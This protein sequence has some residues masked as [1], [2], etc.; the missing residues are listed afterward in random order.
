M[1]RQ[2]AGLWGLELIGSKGA[3]KILTEAIPK[4]YLLKSSDWTAQGR[5]N[6]WHPWPE[7]PT[8]N[9]STAEKSFGPSNRRGVDDWLDSIKTR[10]D[11]V[12]SGRSAAKALEMVMAVYEAAL[13]GH[14]VLLPMSKRTH[15]LAA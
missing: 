13:S 8:L 10:R 5:T 9:W 12:S 11:P 3:V 6:E 4:I 2:T 1:N 7:D 15:P 14:R